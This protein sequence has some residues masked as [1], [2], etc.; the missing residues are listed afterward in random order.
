M[1]VSYLAN[2]VFSLPF[3]PFDLFDK[4][5]RILPGRLVSIGTQAMD[6]VINAFHLGTTDTTA[7]MA[8]QIQA[9]GLILVIGIVLGFGLGWISLRGKTWLLRSALIVGFI[10]SVA[11]VI[12]EITIPHSPSSTLIGSIWLFVLIEGWSLWLYLLINK[13]TAQGE[14]LQPEKK[15]TAQIMSE[16]MTRRNFLIVAWSSLASFGLLLIGS[17]N[18]HPVASAV[19]TP[20]PGV[21]EVPVPIISIPYGPEYTSGLATSPSLDSLNSRLAAAPGTNDEITSVDNFYRVDINLE[22]PKVDVGTWRLNINGLVQNPISLSLADIVA[23]P[24]VSQAITLACISNLVGGSLIGTDYWT[25]VPLRVILNEI[26]LQPGAN[27]VSIRA[28]DS[29]NES[30]SL[31]EAMDERTLLVYAMNG[32]ALTQDHG[33]PLRIYIPGHYGMKQPKWITELAVTSQVTNGYW[34]NLGWSKTAIPQTTSRIDTR[35][36]DTSLLASQGRIPLGGY[37]WAGA[38]TIEKVELQFG[39]STWVEAELRN[40]PVSPLTWVQWRYDWKPTPGSYQVKVR[41]TDGNGNFQEAVNQ[42]PFPEGATGFDVV[43]YQI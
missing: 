33:A 42:D 19:T 14:K 29:F 38:R 34:E 17:Y 2:L 39:D 36:V 20:G 4:L 6:W 3:L 8:G 21:T 41:A 13:L 9:L 26:G 5:T 40:P 27:A 15:F 23:F 7:K 18:K 31:A 16:P 25:G 30:L 10:F 35:T 11:M 43:N 28:V 22:P 12:V 24:A 37:A 1:A 32:Q